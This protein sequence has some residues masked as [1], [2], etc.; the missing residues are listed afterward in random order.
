MD[1]FDG[2]TFHVGIREARLNTQQ[3]SSAP[4]AR[5]EYLITTVNRAALLV[6]RSLL[7]RWL[8][9]RHAVGCE[10]IALNRGR[11]DR[12]RIVRIVC[13]TWIDAPNAVTAVA[14]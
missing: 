5:P 6:V 14:S 12:G 11:I 9:G 13:P 7:H 3:T 10:Y 2:G 1:G 8:P 4:A